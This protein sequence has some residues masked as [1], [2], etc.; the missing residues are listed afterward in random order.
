LTVNQ[1]PLRLKAVALAALLAAAC[2]RA[3]S[4]PE[5]Q[6]GVASQELAPPAPALLFV[7]TGATP[8]G[9]VAAR[10]GDTVITLGEVRREA[11]ARELAEDPDALHPAAPDF[12]RVLQDL[13]DQRLLALEA[14]RRGLEQDPEARRRLAAAQERILGNI[15]VE[16]AVSDVVTEEAVRRVYDEQRRLAP[17]AVEVRARHILVATREEAEEVA[18]LLAE[19]T[20]FAQL[21]ARVSQ[22]PATR[23]EGGDL[24]YFTRQGILPAFADIAF[25]TGEGE[26]SAPFQTEYGWHVLTVIDRRRQAD[27]GLEAR[28]ADIV[29]FLTLQGIDA[30][31]SD[32]RQSYPVTV[33]APASPDGLRR[34]DEAPQADGDGAADPD[35]DR[36]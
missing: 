6:A 15:L 24:G 12:Q 28:R 36:P 30:L 3:E 13:I 11:A 22:D 9:E 2:G 5:S 34:D 20:D 29:R 31:L 14:A 18:R 19:G 10:V 1:A 27:P 25:E 7:E 17:P 35:G 23:L 26:V 33:T 32:I 21:A 16:T 4:G 8:D